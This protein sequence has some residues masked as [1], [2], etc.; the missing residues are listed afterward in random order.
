MQHTLA[1]IFGMP[2]WAEFV[3]LAALGVLIFG[4]R[5]PEVGRSI[6][7][8]IVEFKKG[9]GGIE[10]D[11]DKAGSRPAP[12]PRIEQPPPAASTTDTAQSQATSTD[13]STSEHTV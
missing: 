11:I 2:G 5:L 7:K 13:N 1:V 6:G 8:G 9:L 3:L 12:P 10:D 4:K